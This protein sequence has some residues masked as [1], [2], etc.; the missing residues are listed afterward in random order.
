MSQVNN[1]N[2]THFFT[3]K[4]FKFHRIKLHRTFWLTTI[5]KINKSRYNASCWSK[6][7]QTWHQYNWVLQQGTHYYS[8]L[9]QLSFLLIF[10]H[11]QSQKKLII[12]FSN[13]YLI[14]FHDDFCSDSTF[15]VWK[16][17]QTKINWICD[18]CWFRFL[19]DELL[20][21]ICYLDL[22]K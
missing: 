15:Y 1:S 6:T 10:P 18:F 19:V 3:F 14:I 20:I 21:I 4:H 2:L 16:L 11:E 9:V 17:S 22:I 8:K 5:F 7:Q 13:I 12:K